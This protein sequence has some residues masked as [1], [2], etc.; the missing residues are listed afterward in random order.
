MNGN[1]FARSFLITLSIVIVLAILFNFSM[2]QPTEEVPISELAA[3]IRAGEVE[4]L[5][6]TDGARLERAK[7]PAGSGR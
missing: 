2:E 3:A 4:S 6:V 7:I 1:R 5:T